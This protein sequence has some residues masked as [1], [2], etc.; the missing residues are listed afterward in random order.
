[1]DEVTRSQYNFHPIPII[2]WSNADHRTPIP[3]A[4]DIVYYVSRNGNPFTTGQGIINEVG[5]GLYY[6]YTSPCDFALGPILIS[7]PGPLPA[8]LRFAHRLTV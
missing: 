8:L 4:T 7:I 3:G 6:L 1:M 5:E 2:L